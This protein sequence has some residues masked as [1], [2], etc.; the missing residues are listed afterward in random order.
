MPNI[1]NFEQYSNEYEEWFESNR[2]LYQEEIKSLKKLV[3]NTQNGLEIG[4]GTGRFAL[5]IG[6]KIGVEPSRK[7]RDIAISKGLKVLDGVAE[8]L[9]FKDNTFDFVIMIN[10]VCFVDDL[11]K[12]FQ[13]AFRVIKENGFLIVGFIDKD[14]KLGVEYK[15]K[16]KRSKFYS[17]AKFYSTDEI[18]ALLKIVGFFGFELGHV[19]NTQ[20]S[21]LF[22]KSFKP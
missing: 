10:T 21:F 8:D 19:E 15:E 5:P 1:K 13:E 17:N 11:L 2:S 16:S 20:K 4:I 3:G 18:I 22:L 6:I 12:S 14:S 9:A 7:M